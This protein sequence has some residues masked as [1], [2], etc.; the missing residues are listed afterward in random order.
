MPE[1]ILSQSNVIPQRLSAAMNW[2]PTYHSRK[3]A[4]IF[5]F[6]RGSECYMICGKLLCDAHD[7]KDWK[8]DGS[9]ATSFYQWV[10]NEL[11]HKSANVKRIMGV[12]KGIKHLVPD[13]EDVIT[14]TEFSKLVEIIPHLKGLD[15]E[16]QLELIHMANT[17]SV[18]D[19]R[20][21]IRELTGG[22]ATDVCGHTGVMEQ[23]F[24][25]PTCGKFFRVEEVEE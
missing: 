16:H 1:Q 3:M 5:N 20:N 4:I 2:V 7:K 17:N 25:C 6:N 11:G 12:W 13:H 10:E 18:R 9:G 14:Q 22:I 23:W 19:L 21:N 8:F 15:E 24:K